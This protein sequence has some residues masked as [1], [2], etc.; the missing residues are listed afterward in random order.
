MIK[1]TVSDLPEEIQEM[2]DE[3]GDIVVDDFLNE[4]PPKRDI[5]HHINFIPGA[6]LPNKAGYRL[7]SRENEEARN[8][9]QGLID[10]GLIKKILS[11]CVVRVVLTPNKGGEWRMCTDS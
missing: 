3:F 5:S 10:K 9:V 11:S 2:L 1:T 6:T 7:T 8:Q 4:L